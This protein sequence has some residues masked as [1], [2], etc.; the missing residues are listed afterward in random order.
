MRAKCSGEIPDPRITLYFY[1]NGAVSISE[2][3]LT[4]RG[5]LGLMQRQVRL[6]RSMVEA[7]CREVD[8]SENYGLIDRLP[9]V[10]E[11]HYGIQFQAF[12]G[13]GE[14]IGLIYKIDC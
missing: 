3:S 11:I 5:E 13:V 12:A 10:D 6:Y 7:V 8:E 4:D 9:N 14:E 1:V 2:Y